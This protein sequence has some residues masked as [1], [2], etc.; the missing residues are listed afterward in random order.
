MWIY[1]GGTNKCVLSCT[2]LC[3]LIDCSPPGFSFH[4]IF[5]AR[6][7]E[8][9]AISSS[10]QSS[11]PRDR[12]HVSYIAGDSLPL[13]H[14]GSPYS[15]VYIANNT[16]LNTCNLLWEQMLSVLVSKTQD[17]YVRLSFFL[18][19]KLFLHLKIYTIFICQLYLGKFGN[20]REKLCL[21][22][23]TS[24]L[25]TAVPPRIHLEVLVTQ[26]Y[27]ALCNPTD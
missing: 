4:G 27:L 21:S 11:L 8:W 24:K 5:Q 12:T 2:Q 20:T 26:S 6:T 1:N 10:K 3:D 7:L 16:A 18:H 22:Y 13:S 19:L 14:W 15:M 23:T 25:P 17:N 9:V